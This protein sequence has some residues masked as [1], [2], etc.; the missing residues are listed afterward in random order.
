MLLLLFIHV[1]YTILLIKMSENFY[2]RKLH[3]YI[4]SRSQLLFESIHELLQDFMAMTNYG[5][6]FYSGD[7]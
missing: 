1:V 6:I 4:G 2:D 3:L 5:L 7:R